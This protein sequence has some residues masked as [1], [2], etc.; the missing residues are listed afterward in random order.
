MEFKITTMEHIHAL[1]E[2][3]VTNGFSLNIE[4]CGEYVYMKVIDNSK[5]NKAE[6]E[7]SEDD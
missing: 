3:S 5:A 2:I 6:V 1:T 7:V 4:N